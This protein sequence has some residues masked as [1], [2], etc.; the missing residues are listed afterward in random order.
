MCQSVIRAV[1]SVN[2]IK[3]HLWFCVK[4]N[5]EH[6]PIETDEVILRIFASAESRLSAR[7]F[8]LRA[9]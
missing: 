3:I 1:S 6:G 4:K 5:R 7:L 2:L 9:E 8:C